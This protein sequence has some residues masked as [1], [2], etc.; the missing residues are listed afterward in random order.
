MGE[1]TSQLPGGIVSIIISSF[2]L[3][4]VVVILRS[5]K[6]KLEDIWYLL[7]WFFGFFFWFFN[8]L[9]LL[10]WDFNYPLADVLLIIAMSWAGFHILA[11]PFYLLSKM[12]KNKVAH[13]LLGAASVSGLIYYLFFWLPK[14]H[15][16]QGVSYVYYNVGN[17]PH[18]YLLAIIMVIALIAAIYIVIKGFRTG[19]MSLDNLSSFYA[20][21]ALV[22]YGAVALTAVLYIRSTAVIQVFH[23]LV[24]W[25]VYLGYGKNKEKNS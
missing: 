1:V 18:G 2:L 6:R 19:E 5:K 4:S 15:Q 9:A 3:Y 12:T 23:V 13:S 20:F 10:F 7:F 22:I 21:Y 25:L 8:G 11:G 17:V 14:A 16:V 24:P